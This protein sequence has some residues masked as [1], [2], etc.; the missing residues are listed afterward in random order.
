MYYLVTEM[1]SKSKKAKQENKIDYNEITLHSSFDLTGIHIDVC[2]FGYNIHKILLAPVEY[3][4]WKSMNSA[5]KVA[6][7]SNK[8]NP[9]SIDNDMVL[10]DLLVRSVI[11]V[12]DSII[13]QV[14]VGH[15][16]RVTLPRH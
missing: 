16:L 8:I 13:H 12:V 4:N 1:K 9:K 14:M 3:N 10:F 6:I 11:D 2:Y 15:A 5:Q 7:I